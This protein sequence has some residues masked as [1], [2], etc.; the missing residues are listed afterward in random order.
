M[1]SGS[2]D[3]SYTELRMY[4]TTETWMVP[5]DPCL[6]IRKIFSKTHS[7]HMRMCFCNIIVK[8]C[9]SVLER[10]EEKGVRDGR[11]GDVLS[12]LQGSISTSSWS[13]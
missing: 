7:T 3:G 4:R 12:D 10:Q 13:F 8:I 9:E 5:I 1:S 6:W 11:G 2:L